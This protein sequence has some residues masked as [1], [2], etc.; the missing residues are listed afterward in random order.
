MSTP[1]ANRRAD[2]DWIRV[3]AF[4]LLILYHVG[5]VYAPWDWHVHSRY[6][7]EPLRYAALVT[8][9][10]R[11][12]LLFF[13]SGVALRFMSRRRA[14]GEVL[15]ARLAR[16]APPFFF[17]VLVLVPPQSW[18]E[19]M[20]KGSWNQGLWAWW[21]SEFSPAG[22]ADGIP[23]NHIWFVLYISV[24]SLIIVGLLAL[25]RLQAGLEAAFIRVFSGW[26]LLVIPIIYLAVAR[27][28]LFARFGLS[29]HLTADWYNHAAS[30]GVFLLGFQLALRDEVWANFERLRWL[31]LATAVSALPALIV[32]EA[33]PNAMTEHGGLLKNLVFAIDQWATIGAI[34][35][36]AS[37]HIRNSDGPLLRYLTD[38][39]FPCYLAHQ[40]LLVVA[41][42]VLKPMQLPVAAEAFLFL[43]F[44]LGGSLLVY[45]IVRRI[46]PIR[47][48]WGLKPF[49]QVKGAS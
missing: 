11:L 18:I 42:W 35:G 5:L 21:L 29:N 14:P 27:Q 31:F 30:F 26:R 38:A 39:V 28:L 16:L 2:I 6:T 22:F 46:G 1:P 44:T 47:P 43:T 10:W 23:L 45:E 41:I 37:L 17:G 9:P 49:S 8:N 20:D 24:Y 40:T 12:T 3:A 48:L 25:P 32:L 34:L 19:A 13:V 15:K 7:F 4:G 33:D 36:F